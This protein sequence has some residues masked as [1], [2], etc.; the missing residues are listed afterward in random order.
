[1][2]LLVPPYSVYSVDPYISIGGPSGPRRQY[3][4]TPY[5]YEEFPVRHQ[6]R[7]SLQW[8]PATGSV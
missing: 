6:G 3:D 4:D 2:Y 5:I 8:A 1:M 7:A